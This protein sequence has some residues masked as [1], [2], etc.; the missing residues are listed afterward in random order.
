[1]QKQKVAKTFTHFV[2]EILGFCTLRMRF[3]GFVESR[4][5]VES[6]RWIL[7]NCGIIGC[8]ESVK[9]RGLYF[10]QKQKVA[11]DFRTS[12]EILRKAQNLTKKTEW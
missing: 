10:L 3:C 1:M 11:K 8:L 4:G 12:C 6:T 7:R 2:R 5:I 9:E